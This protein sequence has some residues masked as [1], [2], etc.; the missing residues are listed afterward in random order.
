[1]VNT[2]EM[3]IPAAEI[4]NVEA[5]EAAR[6]EAYKAN[7]TEGFGD[8]LAALAE[9][10]KLRGGEDAP[11]LYERAM[12]MATTPVT[13]ADE[14]LTAAQN[15]LARVKGKIAITGTMYRV[16]MSED[17]GVT[18]VSKFTDLG[19][20]EKSTAKSKADADKVG[21]GPKQN[22]TSFRTNKI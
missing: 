14:V 12:D 8:S 9:Q 18:A 13:E 16:T 6:L 5:F 11:S 19:E 20:D 17:G 2:L 21:Y 7:G 1:M 10:T 15:R 4:A 22:N 3:T